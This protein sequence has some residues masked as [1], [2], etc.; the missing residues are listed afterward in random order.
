VLSR[1]DGRPGA[2]TGS[3]LLLGVLVDQV[4][5]DPRRGH[6]VAL[7]GAA[8][9]RLERVLWRDRRAAGLIHVG[10]LVGGAAALGGVLARP[11]SGPASVPVVAAATWTVVGG[12]SLEREA[13]AVHAHLVD[14]DLPAARQRLTHLV[15]RRTD[16]LSEPDIARA[17][18]E[19]VAENTSDA[20]VAPLVWGAIA[21]VPGLLAYRAVN[22]LDAMV[23][24]HNARYEHFGWASARLDDLA[25]VVP[26][27]LAA[28]LAAALA[29]LVGGGPA[30][31]VEVIH[32][33]GR[34]HPSPNAGMVESAYAAALGVRLGGRND[35]GSRVEERPVLGA[36]GRPAAAEDIPRA[37]RLTRA[38]TGAAAI[39]CAGAAILRGWRR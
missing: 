5:G 16:E 25:N 17:V 9:T 28:A 6:P 11:R 22:T 33:D 39:F 1:P 30:R 36:E 24:H 31:V 38:I 18:V 19:S 29:P 7:F 13:R 20:V 2:A 27:R 3:G 23:G 15:G 8:A 21:G 37:V 12:R 14:G 4:L 32:R 10:L 35:Y 34:R 26:A